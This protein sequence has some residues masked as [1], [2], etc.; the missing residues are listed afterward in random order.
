PPGAATPPAL[1]PPVL[2]EPATAPYPEAALRAG[3]EETIELRLTIDVD[4][5]VTEAE[6]LPSASPRGH[7]AAFAS[8]ARGAALRV[9]FEPARRDGVPVPARIRYAYPFRLPAREPE[10]AVV[11]PLAA[12]SSAGAAPGAPD[13]TAP[14][15]T[16]DVTAAGAAVPDVAA[17]APTRVTEAS[18]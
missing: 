3:V 2:E 6:V 18:A 13:V 9:V 15:G 16:R 5:R 8:A 14:S 17:T 4:G 11:A 1:T 12:E 7:H 10:A